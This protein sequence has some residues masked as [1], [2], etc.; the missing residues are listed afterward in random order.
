MDGLVRLIFEQINGTDSTS[1]GHPFHR[2][3]AMAYCSVGLLLTT[4]ETLPRL[5]RKVVRS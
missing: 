1:D 2:P 5:A 3:C 4:I